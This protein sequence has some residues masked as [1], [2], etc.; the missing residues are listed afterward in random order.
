[1]GPGKDAALRQ[2]QSS[3]IE[4]HEIKNVT[5]HP[6]NGVRKAKKFRRR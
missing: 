1:M 5:P 3:D 4:I 6:H 2:F